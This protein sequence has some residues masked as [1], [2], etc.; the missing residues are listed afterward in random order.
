[1][2]GSNLAG[3]HGAGSARFAYEKHGAKWGIGE[4][5]TGESYAIPTKDHELRSLFL[6]EVDRAVAQFLTFAKEH[7][8]MQFTVVKIGCGLAGFKESEIKPMFAGA[9]DNCI[10]PEGWRD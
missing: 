3:Y 5:L 10:L 7:P 2:F 8:E 4:G 9:P 1:M 6:P